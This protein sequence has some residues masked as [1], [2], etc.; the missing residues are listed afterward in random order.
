MKTL[1]KKEFDSIPDDYKGIFHDF[2]G[3][4]PEWK[5]RRTAFLPGEGTTLFIEGVHFLVTDD[6]NKEENHA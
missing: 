4:H 2:H 6:N 5:G 1:T 3:T